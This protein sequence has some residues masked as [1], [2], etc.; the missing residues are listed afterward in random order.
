VKAIVSVRDLRY[1]Y[2]DGTQVLNGVDLDVFPGETLILLGSN[3]SGKTTFILHLNGILE[4][5][6]TIRVCGLSPN[7]APKEVRRKIGMV[8]QDADEQLFMPT[9]LE[10]VAFG[11]IQRGIEQKEAER[12]ALVALADSGYTADPRRPPYHLS[13][14]EKRRVAIAGAIVTEPEVL[15]LDEPTTSL[16]PP[17]QSELVSLIHKTPQ[18]KIIVTHDAAFAEAV[19]TR[20]VFFEKGRV[21]ASGSVVDLI[22]R[23]NWRLA[24]RRSA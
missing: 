4:G 15:V 19:G 16:D 7:D 8:F 1:A 20:A 5:E 11:L 22:D 10:D 18:T 3:G 21:L 12:L 13:A 17:G 23:F 6:G 24:S 9:V 14:G 2:P